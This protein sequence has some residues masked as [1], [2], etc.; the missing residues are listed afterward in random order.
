MKLQGVI[1]NITVNQR[2][3]IENAGQL[4]LWQNDDLIKGLGISLADST[5]PLFYQLIKE[6]PNAVIHTID[7]LLTEEDIKNLS[8]KNIKLLI[9]GYK[10]LGRGINYYNKNKSKIEQNINW[11][12]E[13]I[14]QL[15]DEFAVI[16]FDNLAIEHLALKEQVDESVW[17][18]TYMGNEGSYTFFIDSV[19]KQFAVSSLSTERFPLLDNVDDMFKV[20][21]EKYVTNS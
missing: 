20:I 4:W 1:C 8:N 16:S 13:H 2:H 11:L 9:L 14:M 19:T 12:K 15:K 5:D 21:R 7:G 17:N 3:F 6:F 10:I 18:N